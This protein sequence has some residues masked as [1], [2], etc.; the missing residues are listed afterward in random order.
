MVTCSSAIPFSHSYLF[1]PGGDIATA[2]NAMGLVSPFDTNASVS[3]SFTT[4][5]YWTGGQYSGTPASFQVF[6]SGTYTVTC[7]R[8]VGEGRS[9]LLHRIWHWDDVHYFNIITEN[10][11]GQWSEGGVAK[12][13]FNFVQSSFLRQTCLHVFLF[14]CARSLCSQFGKCPDQR[15]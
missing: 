7:R 12:L 8:R 14:D 11:T 2:Y 5:G 15:Y 10:S 3:L 6:P 13:V 1:N 9:L 4:E